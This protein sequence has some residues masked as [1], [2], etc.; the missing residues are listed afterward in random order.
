MGSGW[1]GWGE[2]ELAM[3]VGGGERGC[4]PNRWAPWGGGRLGS[5]LSSRCFSADGYVYRYF[6]LLVIIIIIVWPLTPKSMPPAGDE[7]AKLKT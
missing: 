4:G 3:G 7:H 2:G 5:L 1:G 6:L